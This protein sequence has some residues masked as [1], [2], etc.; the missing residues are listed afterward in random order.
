MITA[1]DLASVLTTSFLTE[2]HLGAD[3][4]VLGLEIV[5][6]DSPAAGAGDLAL[7]VGVLDVDSA[8]LLVQRAAHAAGLALREPLAQAP[9]V[10]DAARD[11]ELTVLAVR[12]EVGWSTVISLLQAALGQGAAG[13]SALGREVR[14]VAGDPVYQ[15]MFDLADTVS[16]LLGAPVT[17]EDAQSRVLAYSTGQDDTDSA[18]MSTIFGRQ[19]P[20]TVRHHFRARGV[21]RKLATSNEP[22]FVPATDEGIKARYIVPLKVGGEWLG[23][24]WAVTDAAEPPDYSSE[25]RAAAEL[26]TLQ[27]RRLHAQREMH[28]QVQLDQVRVAIRGSGL[29]WPDWLGAGP[30]RVAVLGGPDPAMSPTARSELWTALARRH[31]WREPLI[32]DLGDDVCALLEDA[33]QDVAAGSRAWFLDVA[34]QEAR[35]NPHIAVALGQP[36]TSNAGLADSLAQARELLLARVPEDPPVVSIEEAWPRLV[37]GRAV[38]GLRE[39]APVSPLTPLLVHEAAHGGHLVE[40]LEAVLDHWGEVARAARALDVHP[41]T[42]RYRLTKLDGLDGLDGWGDVDLEDPAQRLALRLE[43]ARHRALVG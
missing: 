40:T 12:P 5:D 37:L 36:A 9:Q 18:R 15:D 16:R 3:R 25:L 31:G 28:R 42:I 1:R 14:G 11:A 19:V 2:A 41:N 33:H 38:E 26:V 34:G 24:I 20:T 17:I 29:A 43:I 10:R 7:G 13:E 23:S 35:T 27:L 22:I 21:F 32:A 8:T 30:W 4:A 6:P 39:H